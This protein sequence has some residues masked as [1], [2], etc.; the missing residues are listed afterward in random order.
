MDAN[1]KTVIK[2]GSETDPRMPI[3]R[4]D[5]LKRCPLLL[6]TI[7]LKV[8]LLTKLHFFFFISYTVPFNYLLSL[9]YYSVLFLLRL[10]IYSYVMT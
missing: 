10:V 1:Q 3:C 6:I 8:I 9:C 2:S 7:P 4:R 5:G